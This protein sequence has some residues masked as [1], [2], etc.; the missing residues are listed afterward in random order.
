MSTNDRFITK[1]I[2]N[3][4]TA[5]VCCLVLHAIHE[6]EENEQIWDI[7]SRLP[8]SPYINYLISN[9]NCLPEAIHIRYQVVFYFQKGQKYFKLGLSGFFVSEAWNRPISQVWRMHCL[10]S[11]SIVSVLSYLEFQEMQKTDFFGTINTFSH[12]FYPHFLY[13]QSLSLVLDKMLISDENWDISVISQR[14][15]FFW[16][17]LE[18]SHRDP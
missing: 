4:L 13:S 8:R 6:F 16:C 2:I 1:K 10:Y 7:F 14:K 15:D 17:S 12:H 18:M 11:E 9:V 3:N 5:Q